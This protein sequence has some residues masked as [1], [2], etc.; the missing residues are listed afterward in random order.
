MFPLDPI[1]AAYSPGCT[2]VTIKSTSHPE[3]QNIWFENWHSL[4]GSPPPT[5][6]Q[7]LAIAQEFY[8][9]GV[10][11][12]NSKVI[13]LYAALTSLAV[14]QKVIACIDTHPNLALRAMVAQQAIALALYLRSPESLVLAQGSWNSFV[15]AAASSREDTGITD[16][17]VVVFNT[18]ITDNGL[19]VWMRIG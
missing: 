6:E 15:Q 12:D 3:F 19:P 5:K 2:Y 18:F 7:A 4:D 13:A 8:S 9:L 14:Y 10:F 1:L 11:L 17:D 16:E